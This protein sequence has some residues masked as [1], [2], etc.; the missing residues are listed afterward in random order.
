MKKIKE[1]LNLVFDFL[2]TV[3]HMDITYKRK[4]K[5]NEK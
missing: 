5:K 2:A 1:L 3:I 4:K